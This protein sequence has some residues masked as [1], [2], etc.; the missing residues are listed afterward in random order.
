MSE[1]SRRSTV[2][3]SAGVVIEEHGVLLTLRKKG[4]HL[5]ELWEFPGGKVETGESPQAA[6]V[7]ELQ[8]E[9]GIDVVVGDPLEI[10]FHRYAEKD[11]LL[12]FFLARR[13]PGSPEPHALDVG[14]WRWA[15]AHELEPRDFPAADLAVLEKV[16]RLLREGRP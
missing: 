6:L 1:E 8:E 10:T 14:A 4:T 5:A 12:L 15:G 3:V 13:A 7:R 11:V 9:L 16:R 2:V